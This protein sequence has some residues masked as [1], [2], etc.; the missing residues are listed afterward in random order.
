MNIKLKGI[1]LTEVDLSLLRYLHAVKVA[2]YEQI[3]RDVYCGY[4]KASAGNR[5]RKLEDNRFIC[6]K[7]NRMLLHGKR[8]VSLTK[9]GFEHFVKRGDEF[10]VELQSN[11]INHDLALNDIRRRIVTASRVREYQTENEIQSWNECYRKLNS[12]ALFAL[13][14]SRGTFLVPLEYEST[15]K[16]A[17]RY[18]PIV[19]KY[20]Q[21][22]NIPLVAYIADSQAII[23]K[24]AAAERNLFGWDKPKFFYCLKQEFLSDATPSLKNYDNAV[25]PL[26]D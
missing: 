26:G 25:L 14:L 15:M 9:L 21:E 17:L 8:I 1:Y 22:P 2:T 23:D 12:D 24:V 18:E 16:K 5:L 13:E 3:A 4:S 11:A 19:K 6:T 10:V 7:S 20:Y